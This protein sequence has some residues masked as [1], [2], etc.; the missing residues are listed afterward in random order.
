MFLYSLTIIRHVIET[1]FYLL[2]AVAF[3]VYI[4]I[5]YK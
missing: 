4:R 1:A 3:W 2:G 5:N